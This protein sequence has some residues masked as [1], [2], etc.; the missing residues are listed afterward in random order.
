M[1][2]YGDDWT[3]AAEAIADEPSLG[4]PSVP[5]LP[6]LRVES[7]MARNRELA[8]TEEDVLVRRTRLTTM[9]GRVRSLGTVW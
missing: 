2:R 8:L 9:N 1:D 6:V 4:E 3:E 7:I 5:G